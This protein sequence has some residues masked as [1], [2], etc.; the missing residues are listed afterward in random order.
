M[1]KFKMKMEYL[2]CDIA[3]VLLKLLRSN[4]LVD[5]EFPVLRNSKIACLCIARH[6][7]GI[8]ILSV[9]CFAQPARAYTESTVGPNPKEK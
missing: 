9:K 8:H 1:K 3:Q 7:A 4:A 5:V 6:Q 2:K